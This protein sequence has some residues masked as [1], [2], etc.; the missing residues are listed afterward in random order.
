MKSHRFAVVGAHGLVGRQILRLLA[1]R[2]IPPVCV[3]ALGSEKTVGK[4]VSYGHKGTLKIASL[5]NFDFHT[6]GMAFFCGSSS[7]A[8]TY[9][10]RVADAH[11]FVIDMSSHF[12]LDPKVPL[13]VPDVNGQRLKARPKLH[14]VSSPNAMTVPLA[15]LLAPLHQHVG[16]KRMTGATY[17]GVSSLGKEGMDEL[18]AQTKNFF[19]NTEQENKIFSKKIAFNVIPMIDAFMASG[20]SGEEEKIT[21][22]LKKIISTEIKISLTCA[23]VPVFVGHSA[24]LHIELKKPLSVDAACHLFKKSSSLRVI[25][26]D[27]AFITPTESVGES[28]IFVSRLRQDTSVRNGLSLWLSCDN[29]LGSA[30]NGMHI[31]DDLLKYHC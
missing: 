18:H 24:A 7:L 30:L 31:A 6:T 26:R 16:V 11:C 12:R 10:F 22:E 1:E 27:D 13:I 3:S 17:Q 20:Y 23:R 9:A 15:M 29:V 4:A 25:D 8:K 14:I 2:G 19:M 21:F 5:E 28:C